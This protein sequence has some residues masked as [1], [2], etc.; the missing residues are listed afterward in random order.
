MGRLIKLRKKKKVEFS[1]SK[2]CTWK[3]QWFWLVGEDIFIFNSINGD[4]LLLL[5]W[6]VIPSDVTCQHADIVARN[7]YFGDICCTLWVPITTSEYLE[8]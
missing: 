6:L 1:S 7:A 5:K 4:S 3:S 2:V 8:P